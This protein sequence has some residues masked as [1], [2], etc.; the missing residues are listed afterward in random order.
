MKITEVR[1]GM[2][3][4][5][6]HTPFKTALRS[7]SSVEDVVVEIHTDTGHIGYGE[8]PPTGVITG[9]TT[10]SITG[11][12]RDHISK[13]IIGRDVDDFEDLMRAINECIEHNTSAK[14]AVDMALWDLYGQ[15]YKIPVYKLLGG[16]RKSIVTD[17]TISVNDPEE[18]ARDTVDAIRRGYDC[19]K[20]K[21]GKDADLDIRRLIA[22]RDAAEG[23]AILRIDAN[24]GWT[25]K[26]AVRVLNRMLDMGIELELVEQPVKAFDID[27][28]KYVTEHSDVPVLADESVFSPMDA[29]KILQMRAADIVN[30]KLMKCGGIYNALR[31]ATAAELYGAKCMI[32]CMLESKLSVN[33]AVHVACARKV[34]TIVD[35]DGPS[36][37]KEDP[38]LGGAAFDEKLITVSD[39]PGLGIKGIEAGKI[40]YI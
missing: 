2:I 3:S 5:P 39:E 7:V 24:Q 21:V 32:G 27:G 12:I 8:A 38:I 29:I 10:G 40:R 17:I 13:V 4:I 22:V 19:L 23:K 25:P 37:C 33:A 26:E 14:A 36:L 6:L 15:L 9:D 34:I 11:A 31:I 35:L 28:L 20:I 30:I 18:M 16:C 1:L